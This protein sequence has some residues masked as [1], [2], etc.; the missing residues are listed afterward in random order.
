MRR[1]K[2]P[3]PHV[4][5]RKPRHDHSPLRTYT[6]QGPKRHPRRDP[7]D[8]QRFIKDAGL[9]FPYTYNQAIPPGYCSNVP[10]TNL[11]EGE[12]PFKPCQNTLNDF[13]A[14]YSPQYDLIFYSMHEIPELEDPSILGSILNAFL[15]IFSGI[16]GSEE[17]DAITVDINAFDRLYLSLA[18]ERFIRGVTEHTDNNQATIIEYHNFVSPLDHVFTD[19]TMRYELGTEKRQ[20][21]LS[22]QDLSTQTWQ[23][24]TTSLRIRDVDGNPIGAT[25]GD[26]IL[27][28]GEAC[29]GTQFPEEATCQG[30]GYLEGTPTCQACLISES[31]CSCRDKD[32]DGYGAQGTGCALHTEDCND[33][34]AQVRPEAEDVCDGIDNDCDGIIDNTQDYDQDGYTLCTGDC[35]ESNPQVYPGASET[36]DGIDNNCNGLIDETQTGTYDADQDGYLDSNQCS[37]YLDLDCNDQD[38]NI[39]PDTTENCFDGMDNN[40]NTHIDLDDPDC[41]GLVQ[42]P[43]ILMDN[44]ITDL[45]HTTEA[46]CPTGYDLMSMYTYEEQNCPGT[47]RLCTKRREVYSDSTSIVLR[48]AQFLAGDTPCPPGM[49]EA[50]ETT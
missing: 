40:C 22:S 20:I 29:E 6:R 43:H 9:Y 31:G 33:Q 13:K 47:R 44:V 18:D 8:I 1:P 39:N 26:N 45:I 30:L 4:P 28:Y 3:R 19:E 27:S 10:N 32:G 5:H 50:S 41:G 2:H 37:G 36:C 49:T 17:D 38:A 7:A 11:A 14:Y 21:L 24:M 12:N 15:G 46:Q 16:F 42:N 34:D 25:C 23:F 48:D 35:D